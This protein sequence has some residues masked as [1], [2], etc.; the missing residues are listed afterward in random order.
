[1]KLYHFSILRFFATRYFAPKV[2]V[3]ERCVKS[4]KAQWGFAGSLST[5]IVTS[6]VSIKQRCGSLILNSSEEKD[7]IAEA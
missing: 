1:M 7:E 3:G 6:K 4:D 2:M 5:L